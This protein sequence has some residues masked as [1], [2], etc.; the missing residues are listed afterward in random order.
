MRC[1]W[2]HAMLLS[3]ADIM[4]C[5]W[6]RVMLLNIADIMCC[7]WFTDIAHCCWHRAVLPS[8]PIAALN[9]GEILVRGAGW[10]SMAGGDFKPINTRRQAFPQQF[11]T[12][13]LLMILIW[14]C[15]FQEIYT[16]S[17]FLCRYFFHITSGIPR[18]VNRDLSVKWIGNY[19]SDWFCLTQKSSPDSGA[20]KI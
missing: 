19:K 20:W 16:N 17:T 5:C 18:Q 9:D 2:H 13:Q 4:R 14:K 11:L 15:I 8:L 12:P 7:C 3:I 1:C 10:L 6:H